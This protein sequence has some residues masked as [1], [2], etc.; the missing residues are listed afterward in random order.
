MPI[1]RD[2]FETLDDRDGGELPPDSVRVL[3]FLAGHADSAFRPTEIAAETGVQGETL[4]SA[5]SA[6][7]SRGLARRRDAYWAA[8]DD[9]R[10]A[11]LAGSVHGARSANEELGFEDADEWMEH[12]AGEKG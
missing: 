7:E 8:G 10:L 6:L 5:L 11:G 12:A 3:R 1:P 4:E 2:R 9:H